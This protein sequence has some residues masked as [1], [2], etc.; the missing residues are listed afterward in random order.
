M[1][2]MKRRLM[3][4]ALLGG[5]PVLSSHA[6]EAAS[7]YPSRPIKIIVPFGPG[8]SND[9][10]ARVIGA[11]ISETLKQPVVVENR[12]GAG[13]DIGMGQ[14]AR[15]KADGYTLL[16]TSNAATV[17]TA[18]KKRPVIDMLKDLQP[19][20]MIGTQPMLLVCSANLGVDNLAAFVNAA[21]ASPDKYSF[22]TPG[23]ATPHHLTFEL[24]S[25]AKHLKMIHVPFP[26]TGQALNEVLADRV[27]LALATTASGGQLVQQGRLKVLAVVAAQRLK[28]YPGV[29]TLIEA[30]LGDLES[31][32]WYGFTAPPGLPAPIAAKLN[33]A[34]AAALALPAVSEQVRKMD[35]DIN[36]LQG[37]A[38]GN[39]IATD[40][41]RWKAVAQKSN[42]AID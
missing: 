2:S 34:F 5:L 26:S 20:T 10:L 16:M 21:Q 15:S 29:P 39:V 6:Q 1:P 31:G 19:L 8:A 18:T 14:A 11:Q 27:S 25:S 23:A 17:S 28:D 32:F 37:A 24:I 35:I 9:T 7:G 36:P 38:F 30:G 13:G 42:I 22:A 12:T 4:S 41:K 33:A 3:L 40:Y